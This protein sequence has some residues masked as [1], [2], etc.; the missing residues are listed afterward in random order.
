MLGLQNS[1]QAAKALAIERTMRTH[2]LEVSITT[3]L[4]PSAPDS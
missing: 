1:L 3:W 4:D 2:L